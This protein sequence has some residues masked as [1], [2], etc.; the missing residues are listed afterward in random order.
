MM[1]IKNDFDPQNNYRPCH[2]NLPPLQLAVNQRV[3]EL[4]GYRS[5]HA[6]SVQKYNDRFNMK[7]PRLPHAAKVSLRYPRLQA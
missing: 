3:W 1:K 5:Y 7:R 4:I 6:Y 2:K